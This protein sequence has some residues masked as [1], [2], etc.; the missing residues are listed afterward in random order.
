M[1]LLMLDLETYH[2]ELMCEIPD[3]H[4]PMLCRIRILVDFIGNKFAKTCLIS[5][6]LACEAADRMPANLNLSRL[7]IVN[8]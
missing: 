7:S 3:Q 5:E 6:P 4:S 1:H 8:R 2:P